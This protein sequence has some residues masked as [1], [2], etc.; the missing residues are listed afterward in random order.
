MPWAAAATMGSAF[1]ANQASNNAVNAANQQ[2]AANVAAQERWNRLQDPF[3][4]GGNREQYVSQLQDLL[5]GGYAG[6]QND[7][8][9]QWMQRQG[10]DQAQ[11]AGSATGMGGSGAEQLALQ[12]QGFG[13]ANQ[14]FNQQYQRLADL[15][16]ATRGG[17]QAAVGQSPGSLY[18]MYTDQGQSRTNAFAAGMGGLQ[19]L[20][21]AMGGANRQPMPTYSGQYNPNSYGT[22]DPNPGGTNPY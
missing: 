16:G 1:L 15:S 13:L 2:N 9:F 14:F 20:F 19:G 6:I 22:Y 3:S 8:M 7:P 17:G 4:A 12:Q 10:L 18:N 21:G 5:R 11:R